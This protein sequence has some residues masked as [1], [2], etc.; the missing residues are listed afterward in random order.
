MKA[1][2]SSVEKK[3]NLSMGDMFLYTVND[4]ISIH[5]IVYRMH[6]FEQL[7]ATVNNY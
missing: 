1:S 3:T 7:Q 4:E 6:N 2:Q 5:K